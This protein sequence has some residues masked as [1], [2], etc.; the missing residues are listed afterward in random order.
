MVRLYHTLTRVIPY[1]RGHH[2]PPTTVPHNVKL[3]NI[4]RDK[5][6]S[7]QTEIYFNKT[8]VD[9]KFSGVELF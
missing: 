8:L 9:S 4:I 5:S 3:I 1:S 2:L 7:T 6:F